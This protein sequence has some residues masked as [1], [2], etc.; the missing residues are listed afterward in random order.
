HRFSG[1]R[2]IS[3]GDRP[4]ADR[5][6]K[7]PNMRIVLSLVTTLVGVVFAA[8]V[9]RQFFVRRRPYQLVW[10]S[11]LLIFAVATCCQLLA[12][13][14][15]WTPAIYRAWYFFGAVLGAAYLGQGTLYLLGPRNIADGFLTLLL[16]LSAL[17]AFYVVTLP[18][19]LA[20]AV[21][22]GGQVTGQGF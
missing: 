3:T 10:G 21:S 8:L 1:S 4:A 14:I 20:R 11:A 12:E 13:V 9:L 17:G 22:A 16:V 18:V 6:A 5:R 7:P 2:G 15:G 19:D